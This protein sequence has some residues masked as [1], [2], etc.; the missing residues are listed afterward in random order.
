VPALRTE[1]T[2][3]VTG[4]GMLGAASIEGA[5]EH[6]PPELRNVPEHVWCR[7]QDAARR[8]TYRQEFAAAFA[9]G[10]AFLCAR[11][12]LRRRR[13]LVVEW[14]GPKRAPGDEIVPADLRVDHVYLVSCKYLSRILVNASPAYLF[15]RALAGPQGTPGGD[16]YGEVAAAEYQRL[17]ED[18][19]VALG[20]G[21]GLPPHAA[22]L[23]PAHRVLLKRELP[24][25]AP[26]GANDVYRDLADR[27]ARASADRWRRTLARKQDRERT[28][29]RLLRMTAAPYFVLGTA[30]G[31]SLRV[32]VETPWE[33]R[34]RHDLRRFDVW[35]G[36][37]GQPVVHWQAVVR[38]RA[39]CTDV[40][41]DGHVEIRWS[42]GRFAQPPEAKV[43]LDTPHHRVPGYVP[44]A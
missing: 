26:G 29:W 7:L 13:P 23:T 28:L 39:T 5:L 22:D 33:W 3:I 36:E 24:A 43:Y 15:D 12:A 30:D 27:V 40:N 11:E 37:A 2:E 16:W 8:G 32:R 17:Y 4:L 38:D 9:N 20:S 6:Q 42:H 35:A 25:R 44:I 31:R 21:V 34:I 10:A 41:V 18:V 14:R 19:R 1:I